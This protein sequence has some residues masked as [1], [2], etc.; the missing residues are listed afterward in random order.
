MSD[1]VK[2]AVAKM[3]PA[4][5]PAP[6]HKEPPK[7][8]RVVLGQDTRVKYPQIYL[9]IYVHG[10]E[11]EQRRFAEMFVRGGCYKADRPDK[12]DL[13]VFAGST[14]VDPAL[15]HEPKH[16]MTQTPNK[17]EDDAALKMFRHCKRKGIPMLGVCKG[18]QILHVAMGGKLY[19]HIN[20]HYGDHSIRDVRTDE[21]IEVVS[22]N[23]HQSVIPQEGM[24]VLAVANLSTNKW[25]TPLVNDGTKSTDVE[26]FFYENPGIIGIQGHPEYRGYDYYAAWVLQLIDDLI[27]SN[28][29]FELADGGL[30]RLMKEKDKT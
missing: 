3:R 23:H 11:Y 9:S 26:A 7:L 14:D 2:A 13:V 25:R 22:S 15:Y 30:R 16:A 27:N 19:Q 18:A 6:V 1:I 29:K 4:Q 8:R 21:V 12:A 5:R 28:P 17:E 10:T 20:N 24:Q